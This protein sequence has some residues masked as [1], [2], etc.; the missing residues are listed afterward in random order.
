MK[1]KADSKTAGGTAFTSKCHVSAVTSFELQMLN[2]GRK[3][4]KE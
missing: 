1:A 3:E 4:G 2:E